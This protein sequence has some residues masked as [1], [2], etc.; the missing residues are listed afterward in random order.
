MLPNVSVGQLIPGS[1]YTSYRSVRYC[2]LNYHGGEFNYY[3][4]FSVAEKNECL[5]KMFFS[6]ERSRVLE[7]DRTSEII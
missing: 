6:L 3:C 5:P 1:P 2:F 4:T 7:L